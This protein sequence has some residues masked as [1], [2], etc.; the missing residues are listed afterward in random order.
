MLLKQTQEKSKE[1]CLKTINEMKKK[2]K[3]LRFEILEQ[4]T[5]QGLPFLC[6]I[7]FN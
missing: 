7:W 5:F 1:D 6:K 3:V 4:T 2:R